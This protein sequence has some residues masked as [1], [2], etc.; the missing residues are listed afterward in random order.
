MEAVFWIRDILVRIRIRVFVPLTKGS[1]TELF[2]SSKGTVQ[3]EIGINDSS[4][5][6]IAD[7][8]YHLNLKV[9]KPEIILNF[10]T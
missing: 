10:F 3:Q 6:S 8:F 2:I 7:V 1:G 4:S 5:C 9:R